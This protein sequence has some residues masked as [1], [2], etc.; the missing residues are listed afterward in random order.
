[1]SHCLNSPLS[2]YMW[3]VIR[4]LYYRAVGSHIDTESNCFLIMWIK[5]SINISLNFFIRI[6]WAWNCFLNLFEKT[7]SPKWVILSIWCIITLPDTRCKICFW[8][9]Y[10]I[11]YID[12]REILKSRDG[13][14]WRN[15][16]AIDALCGNSWQQKSKSMLSLSSSQFF[17][18]KSCFNCIWRTFSEL[19]PDQ[20]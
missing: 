2:A 12:Q 20:P 5:N 13:E 19:F 7:D 10:F 6:S 11:N 16:T 15:D 3:R 17:Q 14:M 8:Y 4:M 1:M 9:D 18:S